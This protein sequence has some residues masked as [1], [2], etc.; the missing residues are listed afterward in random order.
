MVQVLRA[1]VQIAH[2]VAVQAEQ[3]VIAASAFVSTYPVAHAEQSAM[4]LPVQVAQP[5]AQAVQVTTAAS[6][7]LS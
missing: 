5:V 2:P 6:V 3:V 7:L 1:V 4:V